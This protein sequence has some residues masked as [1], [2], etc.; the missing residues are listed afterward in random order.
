MLSKRVH[1]VYWLY[2]PDT[3]PP[4][5]DLRC[6]ALNQLYEPIDRFVEKASHVVTTKVSLN[7]IYRNKL[8]SSVLG[9]PLRHFR[10]Y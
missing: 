5:F 2:Y 8:T 4:S 3:V 1:D 10:K 9:H 7:I 6:L